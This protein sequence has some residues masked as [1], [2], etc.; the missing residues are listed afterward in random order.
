MPLSCSWLIIF[1]SD[2][3]SYD[4]GLDKIT[5]AFAFEMFLFKTC[6]SVITAQ[7]AFCA[8]FMLRRNDAFPDR[9]SIRFRVEHF[10]NTGSSITRKPLGRPWSVLTPENVQTV[11]QSVVQSPTRS[12]H[13]HASALGLSDQIKRKC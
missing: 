3:S 6:E 4:Y 9:K 2:A 12:A 5:R 10:R 8:H 13:K 11:R 1:L 7:K